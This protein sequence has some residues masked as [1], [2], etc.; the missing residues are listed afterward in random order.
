MTLSRANDPE[1]Y[2]RM[3]EPR[4]S[5]E[6]GAKA[7]EAFLNAVYELRQEHRIGNVVVIA[8]TAAKTDDGIIDMMGT[9]RYGDLDRAPKLAAIL[10]ASV[11]SE[12]D[13]AEAE[14]AENMASRK[15]E[16]RSR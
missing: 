1:N 10:H 14:T 2:E 11:R 3:N 9:A 7:I 6:D 4:E 16:A 5:R 13:A 15:K 12:R 8:S